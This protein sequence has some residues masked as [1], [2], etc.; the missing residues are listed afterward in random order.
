LNREPPLILRPGGVTFEQLKEIVP[1]IQLYE[2]KVHGAQLAEQPPTPGLK[3]RHYSPTAKVV[4]FEESNAMKSQLSKR[5]KAEVSQ[6]K[7][8]AIIHTHAKIPYSQSEIEGV[9]LYALGD[10]THPELVAQGIFKALR[11]LD[12][13]KIETILIEGVSFHFYY[14]LMITT[15]ISESHEGMAVMNRIRKAASEI[16]VS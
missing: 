9:R 2:K 10:E 13:E 4:L 8:V 11:D 7:K 16:I 15:K 12:S 5:L 3:Y 6:G 14:L 1:D